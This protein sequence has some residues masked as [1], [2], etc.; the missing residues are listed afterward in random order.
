VTC[1]GLWYEGC[2]FF[3]PLPCCRECFVSCAACAEGCKSRDVAHAHRT[4]LTTGRAV[5]CCR[6][7]NGEPGAFY[8][9][10]ISYPDKLREYALA[11]L[12]GLL[13]MHA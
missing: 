8:G 9:S 5:C 1:F 7:Q 11:M 6:W 3:P 13:H 10:A 12:F 2:Q 4:R